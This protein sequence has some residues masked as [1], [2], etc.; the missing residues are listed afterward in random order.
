VP[1]GNLTGNAFSLVH[2]SFGLVFCGPEGDGACPPDARFNSSPVSFSYLP[3]SS[4]NDQTYNAQPPIGPAD[5]NGAH[6]DWAQ[7]IRK[8]ANDAYK[9]AFAQLPAIVSQG[10]KA[11]PIAAAKGYEHTVYVSSKWWL[12]GD[13]GIKGE[14]TGITDAFDGNCNSAHICATSNVYYLSSMGYAQWALEFVNPIGTAPLSPSYPPSNPTAA[15]QFTQVMTAIGTGIG[16]IAVHETGHQLSLPQ[17]D[18][19]NGTNVA[20]SEEFIYQNG[21]SAGQANEWFY[22]VGSGH[23]HW[24]SDAQCKIYKFLGMRNTGCPN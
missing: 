13:F 5:F 10:W 8:K 16:N 20:C 19:S 21:N 17:M 23:I 1:G 2:H 22:G 7:T 9:A 15:A 18:C 11:N 14:P 3:V 24:S 12:G 4:L 6:P